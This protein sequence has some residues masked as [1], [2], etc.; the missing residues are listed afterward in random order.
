MSKYEPN[1]TQEQAR[2][3]ARIKYLRMIK[4]GEPISV[5]ARKAGVSVETWIALEKWG[6]APKSETVRERIANYFNIP[7]DLLFDVSRELYE[8][9]I[10][11]HTAAESV[12]KHFATKPKEGGKSG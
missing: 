4:Q 2:L 11:P 1:L 5:A 12:A 9:P 8:S 6:V 3:A 10:F 7:A